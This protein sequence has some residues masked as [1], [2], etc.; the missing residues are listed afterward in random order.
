VSGKVNWENLTE[1]ILCNNISIMLE[2]KVADYTVQIKPTQSEDGR[3]C[4]KESWLRGGELDREDGP[5]LI[6]KDIEKNETIETGYYQKGLLHRV[7][8]RAEHAFTDNT[9]TIIYAEH[10]KA[11]R[12]DGPA[13]ID[14]NRKT[15][16]VI[17]TAWVR[18]DKSHREDGP[19]T[20]HRDPDSG[21]AVVTIFERHGL[22]HRTDGPAYIE[23]D[24]ETGIITVEDYHIDGN[25]HRDNGPASI[26]RDRE[27]GAINRADFYRNGVLF[28]PNSPNIQ[29]Q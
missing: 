26:E 29:P 15:N 3:A 12:V 7:G 1:I 5:A 21:I 8:K 25:L 17:G 18:N 4:V 10:G 23:R 19:S 24:K 2:F 14:I 20:L 16:L 28:D 22:M 9:E 11:H 6:I 13:I 27:T